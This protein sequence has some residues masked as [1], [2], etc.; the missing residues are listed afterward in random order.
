[1][2]SSDQCFC[3]VDGCATCL[4]CSQR[5]CETHYLH[6]VYSYNLGMFTHWA[7]TTPRGRLELP[8][9][10]GWDKVAT[11]AYAA[12]TSA[13]TRCREAAADLAK[14]KRASE[15]AEHV[16]SC[17][18]KP[19]VGT[20]LRLA[21]AGNYLT[22]ADLEKILAAS[23]PYLSPDS[24]FITVRVDAE[25]WGFGKNRVRATATVIA[26]EPAVKIYMRDA[27]LLEGGRLLP[28]SKHSSGAQA[29]GTSLAKCIVARG[30][31]P[32]LVCHKAHRDDD[33]YPCGPSVRLS[34]GYAVI[35]EPI[36]HHAV[37]GQPVAPHIDYLGDVQRSLLG[38]LDSLGR[39]LPWRRG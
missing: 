35:D 22:A 28:L 32:E 23:W 34:F 9:L 10:E 31:V 36:A 37:I 17:L 39:N 14:A 30:V 4:R 6:D 13:C 18:E 11:Q 26:R 5:R 19:S 33:G 7:A 20:F 16:R 8:F 29:D 3:G 38:D 21:D 1:M 12:G 27:V 2:T 25:R 15:A 24:D